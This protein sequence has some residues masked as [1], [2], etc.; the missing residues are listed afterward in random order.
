MRLTHAGPPQHHITIPKHAPLKVGTLS[1]ILEDV[2]LAM[3]TTRK[4]LVIRLFG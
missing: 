1:G 2:A 4:D 3:K